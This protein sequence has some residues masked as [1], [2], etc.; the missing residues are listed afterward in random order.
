MKKLLLTMT[1]VAGLA[2][3]SNAQEFG[4]DKGNF[5]VEGNLGFNT[6]DNKNAEIKTTNFN[7]NPQVG[8]FVTDKIAVGIFAKVG[9][10][11]EDNYGE[12]VDIQEKASTFDIGAFGRYYFLE[13]G[14]RFKTYAEVAAGYESENG[15]TVTA[16][17][18]VKDPKISG[19]GANAGI[20]AQFFLT[21]KI[22]V[23]YKFAN[24]IGFNSSKVDV[25]GAKA[26]TGFNVNLNSFENF[27]NSGQFGLT[28]KF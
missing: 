25:D 24:V 23:N 21:D 4:F 12:G 6:R 9:T 22:A 3:V 26:T 7:F 2:L 15:E 10:S 28:F 27:F 14:S 20:G 8:Y 1:A 17:S 16:G 19:F 5:I 13:L 11:N 18:S